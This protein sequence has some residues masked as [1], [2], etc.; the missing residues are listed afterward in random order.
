MR[1]EDDGGLEYSIERIGVMSAFY[2]ALN[3]VGGG[4][5][6]AIGADDRGKAWYE[7]RYN[8]ENFQQRG[9]QLRRAEESEQI[10][11]VSKAAKDDPAER[12]SDF[13]KALSTLFNADDA[14]GNRIFTR[15]LERDEHD[16]F[17]AAI[18]DELRVLRENLVETLIGDGNALEID[19]VQFDA[20]NGASSIA[21]GDAAAAETTR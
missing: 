9:A 18:A 5:Q 6:A 2:N 4:L 1:L 8:H 11:L 3:L 15:I 13:A 19:W 17:N 10:G 20:T 14:A 7:L 12:V 21:A 16:D